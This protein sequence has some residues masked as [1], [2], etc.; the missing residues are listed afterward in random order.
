LGVLLLVNH[1]RGWTTVLSRIGIA[2]F[3]IFYTALDS[4]TGIAG[5]TIVRNSRDLSSSVQTFAA[6]QFHYLLFDPIVGG[7]TFSAIGVLGSGG[8]IVGVIAAAIALKR[9]GAAFFSVVLLVAGAV[10]FGIAHVPP[11]GPLGMAC[12]FIAVLTI[13]SRIWDGDRGEK[14]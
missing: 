5:G 13:D 8:W 9:A 12:F 11:T 10:L 3:L 2:F 6:K 1:L 14:L 4:I 7:S